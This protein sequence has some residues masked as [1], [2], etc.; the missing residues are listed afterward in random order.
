M[1][2]SISS[3]RT[4]CRLLGSRYF[5]WETQLTVPGSLGQLGTPGPVEG[6][7]LFSLGQAPGSIGSWAWIQLFPRRKGGHKVPAGKQSTQ[8]MKEHQRAILDIS[9]Y[10]MG[11]LVNTLTAYHRIFLLNDKV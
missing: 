3:W 1:F 7:S 5:V 4:K 9:Y 6:E 11:Q 2:Y 10:C 8:P